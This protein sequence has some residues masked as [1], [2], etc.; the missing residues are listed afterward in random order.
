[1]S[2]SNCSKCGFIISIL[3]LACLIA[4]CG[5]GE[6]PVGTVEDP[7]LTTSDWQLVSLNGKP[8]RAETMAVL[9]FG[10]A[11]NLLGSTGCNLIAGTYEIG[12]GSV[13]SFISNRTTSFECLEPYLT[14]ESAMLL[15]LSSSSNYTIEGDELTVTNPDGDRKGSFIRMSPLALVGTNWDLVA[16]DRGL[17]EFVNVR[18]GTQITASFNVDGRISGFGGCNDYNTTYQVEGNEITIG[19]ILSTQKECSDPDGVMEQEGKYLKALETADTY[20]NLGIVL[21]LLDTSGHILAI[22]YSGELD[23]NP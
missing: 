9:A 6:T 17:G 4:S 11:G 13:L 3:I 23:Q 18:E 21:N 12:I 16:F 5:S 2:F 1:L 19:P 15:V 8:V 20:R 10:N 7:N 14:Q 22:Y